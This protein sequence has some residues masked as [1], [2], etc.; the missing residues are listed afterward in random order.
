MINLN[1]LIQGSSPEEIRKNTLAALDAAL[2]YHKL[3]GNVANCLADGW[4]FEFTKARFMA[5][6]RHPIHDP[7]LQ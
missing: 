5:D 7:D 4:E 6:I 3:Y 1:L 2:Y